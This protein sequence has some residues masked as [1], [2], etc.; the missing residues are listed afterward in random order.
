MHTQLSKEEREAI[1]VYYQ[2]GK[3][4]AEIGRIVSRSH[5]TI[6]REI[7]RNGEKNRGKLK[8]KYSCFNAHEKAKETRKKTNHKRRKLTRNYR[9]HKLVYEKLS[10]ESK[11]RSPEA[12]SGRLKLERGINISTTTIYNYIHKNKPE[13]KRYLRYK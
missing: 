8:I 13:R 2:Q 5:T 7:I 3:S 12:I 11:I 9:L 10:D 1:A 4:Y 6:M